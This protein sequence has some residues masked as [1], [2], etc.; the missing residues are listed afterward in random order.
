L[1]RYAVLGTHAL[2]NTS[3]EEVATP[4]PLPSPE[5]VDDAM[6]DEAGAIGIL[7]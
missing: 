5:D 7:E 4:P 2:V 3:E 6:S 1:Y